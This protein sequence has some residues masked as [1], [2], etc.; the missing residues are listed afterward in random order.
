MF[1]DVVVL[2]FRSHPAYALSSYRYE[3]IVVSDDGKII[4]FCKIDSNGIS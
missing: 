3:G 4:N 2:D 1:S